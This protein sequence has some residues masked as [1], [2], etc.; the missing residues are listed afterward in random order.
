MNDL[1]HFMNASW[2]F[3]PFFFFSSPVVWCSFGCTAAPAHLWWA[4]GAVLSPFLQE[5]THR[6]WPGV[7]T[8]VAQAAKRKNTKLKSFHW[9]LHCSERQLLAHLPAKVCT[10]TVSHFHFIFQ[11]KTLTSSNIVLLFSFFFYA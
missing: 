3:F 7:S 8:R 6:Q 1:L 10:A 2:V 11:S 9:W 5:A 4:C